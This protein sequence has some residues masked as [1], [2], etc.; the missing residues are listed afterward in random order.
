MSS[1]QF[2]LPSGFVYLLKPQQ[3]WAPLPQPHC[4][5][6]GRSQTAVL[7]MREA[8]WVWDPPGQ[9]WD[10]ISWCACLLKAQYWG[11]S[12]PI[13]QVLCVSVPL[14]RKRDSLPPCASQVRQ[15]LALLQLSLVGLQQLTSTDRPALPSEMNPVPQ[16]KMQKSPVFCVARAGSWRLE[17]FLFGHLA[18]PP[19]PSPLT[20]KIYFL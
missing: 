15:C 3:W 11:G 2:E 19:R 4:C 6:A 20:F 10:M 13:F 5:L 1:T 16:L 17:L 12:Y 14:A 7:A 8:P 9:V 18:P